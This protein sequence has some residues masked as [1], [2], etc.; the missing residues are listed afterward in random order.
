[1]P[2]EPDYAA[3]DEGDVG[4]GAQGAGEDSARWLDELK[5]PPRRRPDPEPTLSIFPDQV[6]I[7]DRFTDAE[8][9]DEPHE[10]D[11]ISPAGHLQ[12]GP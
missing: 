9:G 11:V 12:T 5:M 7:G 8:T 2:S 10:W 3:H 4:R 6:H 1:M